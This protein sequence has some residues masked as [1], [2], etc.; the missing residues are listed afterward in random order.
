MPKFGLKLPYLSDWADKQA[1]SKRPPKDWAS[2]AEP[3]S[4]RLRVG[5][6]QETAEPE[7]A[8]AAKCEK[9]AAHVESLECSRLDMVMANHSEQDWQESKLK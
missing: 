9:Y 2:D 7:S 8:L 5:L 6:P 4:K 3:A 1:A